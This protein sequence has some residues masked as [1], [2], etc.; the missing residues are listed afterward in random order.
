MAEN[1]V[2]ID[3]EVEGVQQA[4]RDLEK[5]QGSASEIGKSVKGLIV[6]HLIAMKLSASLK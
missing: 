5:V 3:V 4:Q 1:R 6:L 2:V